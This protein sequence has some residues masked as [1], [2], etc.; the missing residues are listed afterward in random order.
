M[1]NNVS[2][3][4]KTLSISIGV[5]A[6][7]EEKNIAYVIKSLF[8][9]KIKR[10]HVKEIIVISDGS[11]DRTY[12]IAKKISCSNKIKVIRHKRRY[13]KWVAINKFLELA[14]SHVLVLTD[15]DFILDRNVIE[16]LCTPFLFDEKL[17]MTGAHLIPVNSVH[18][19]FG[20]VANL[21]W[22]LHH[23]LSLIQPKFG[24]VIAF[25]NVIN[26]LP[27]TIVDEEC[28][29]SIIKSSSY[30]LKYIPDA[31]VYHKGPEN[32]KDFFIQRSRIYRGHLFLKKNYNYE[33]TTLSGVR[34]LRCLLADLPLEYRKNRLWL[35]GAILLEIIARINGRLRMFFNRNSY[36][37]KWKIAK[38]TK[39]IIIRTSH[40]DSLHIS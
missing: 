14:R 2:I 16:R 21:Q 39:D 13:G 28:I 25:R 26:R 18:S 31:I 10:V 17:G 9:Q 38:S 23:K 15:A 33:V 27:P 7:N 5:C 29:A 11:V 32:M 6:Y 4:N 34:I 30:G 35:L 8:K 37:Y 20:Y 3:Q 1:K 19:F 40:I 36:D 22:H 24:G 12:E